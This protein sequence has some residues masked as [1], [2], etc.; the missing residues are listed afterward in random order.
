MGRIDDNSYIR[1][2]SVFLSDVGSVKSDYPSYTIEAKTDL[3]GSLLVRTV[4]ISFWVFCMFGKEGY[5]NCARIMTQRGC[6]QEPTICIFF[7][8][9]AT[10]K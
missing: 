4:S 7:Y 5:G 9:T 1:S 8:L 6:I 3:K 2:M 10:N